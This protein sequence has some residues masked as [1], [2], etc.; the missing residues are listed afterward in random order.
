[1]SA[2]RPYKQFGNIRTFI[3][4]FLNDRKI[5]AIPVGGINLVRINLVRI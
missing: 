3:K 1:M 4:V 2:M 5:Q